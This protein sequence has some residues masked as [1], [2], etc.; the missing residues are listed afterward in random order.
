MRS[1]R[2]FPGASRQEGSPVI[3]ELAA[4][5]KVVGVK[6]S[7]KA[8]REGRAR[9]VYLACDADPAVTGAVEA[10]CKSAGIPVVTNYT[11]AQ[12]GRACAISVGA[13]VVAVL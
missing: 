5:Q 8:V 10:S 6:Q 12:L 4:V 11:M 1:Y 2:L 13:S 7:R 3:S 9:Q